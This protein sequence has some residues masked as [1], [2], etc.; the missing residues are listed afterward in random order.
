LSLVSI[1]E[2]GVVDDSKE[3]MIEVEGETM[4][5]SKGLCQVRL[6]FLGDDP[7]DDV[8]FRVCFKPRIPSSHPHVTGVGGRTR[9]ESHTLHS[10][11][12]DISR[13]SK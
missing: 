4:I 6:Q 13:F 12:C 10:P 8:K 7:C 9:Q 3:G 5:R 11:A 2:E 1:K